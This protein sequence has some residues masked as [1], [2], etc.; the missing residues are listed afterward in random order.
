R[1]CSRLVEAYLLR[2]RIGQEFAATV[3]DRGAGAGGLVQLAGP[4]VLARCDGDLPLGERVTVRLIRAEPATRQDRFALASP[5]VRPGSS[6]PPRRA[7]SNRP[8][9]S[10]S[11]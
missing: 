7:A 4:A 5:A 11:A 3:I 10:R 1:A 2:D 8:P 9:S 6:R